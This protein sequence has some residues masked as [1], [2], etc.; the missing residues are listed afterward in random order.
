MKTQ[1]LMETE[2]LKYLRG[3]GRVHEIRMLTENFPANAV[4]F[5]N[6]FLSLCLIPRG[7]DGSEMME[8]S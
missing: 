1:F 2:T 5:V 6:H 7:G 3:R 4:Y 8:E